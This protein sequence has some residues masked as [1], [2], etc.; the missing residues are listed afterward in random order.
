MK[1]TEF[2]KLFNADI[3]QAASFID[4]HGYRTS[5]IIT[6]GIQTSVTG[7][8]FVRLTGTVQS[9]VNLKDIEILVSTSIPW[10]SK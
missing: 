2:N 1:K 10:E 3:K 4:R 5:A 7:N 9:S 8:Q 6:S